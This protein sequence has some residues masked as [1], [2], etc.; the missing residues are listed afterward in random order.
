MTYSRQADKIEEIKK[1]LVEVI[2]DYYEKGFNVVRTGKSC[3]IRIN[4]P[5]ITFLNSF[6]EQEELVNQAFQAVDKLYNLSMKLEM[7]G[8]YDLFD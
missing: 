7:K 3:A 4:V 1:F 2:G 8:I 6:E 5:V